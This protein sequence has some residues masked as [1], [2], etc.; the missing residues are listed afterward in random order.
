M[1]STSRRLVLLEGKGTR[2]PE[3]VRLRFGSEPPGAS[4]VA[5]TGLFIYVIYFFHR[6]PVTAE[7]N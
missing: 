6:R 7:A 5:R 3:R 4:T 2:L 1:A